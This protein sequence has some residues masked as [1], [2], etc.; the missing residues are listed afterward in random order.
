[1]GTTWSVKFVGS[2]ASAQT[3][4]RAIP[5]VLDRVI[6]QMSP[7]EPRSDLSRFNQLRCGEWQALPAEFRTV[8]QHAIRIAA[9]TE[10]AYDPAMGAL[11]DLWG[12]GPRDRSA[13]PPSPS[14]TAY[15]LE[16]CGW[17]QVELSADGHQLRRHTEV[18]IDLNGIAKG[19][20]VDLVMSALREYGIHHALVEI[21]GELSGRGV[22]PDGTPW[23]VAIDRSATD[24]APQA[25]PSL[26]VAL[27]D[28]AI[29]TSG[30]E[31]SFEYQG[32][33]YSHTIDPRTGR[34]ISNGMV[35]A[36]VLHPSCM[37]ADAYATALMVM[38]PE[39][40]MR[41]A[42]QQELAAVIL[43]HADKDSSSIE[44]RLTPTLQAML[45]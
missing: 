22:K 14:D 24:L 13:T 37:Q 23:W 10:G 39:A 38:G 36:T 27:H 21:G 12:F 5:A 8:M 18:Q 44:E 4:R 19:Y 29:A 17:R 16:R 33:I 7:W 25:A 30:C 28:L 3:M 34:P 32:Q 20:A 41:F 11:V 1:M 15:T 40:S 9:E 31:R 2:E 43:Y 6:A 26:L 45:D 42:T 35:M